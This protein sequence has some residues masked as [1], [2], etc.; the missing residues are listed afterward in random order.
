MERKTKLKK[1]RNS[2]DLL[3]SLK[4]YYFEII[5]DKN[6]RFRKMESKSRHNANFGE[7]F[8]PYVAF[9]PYNY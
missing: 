3:L 2:Y 7:V 1:I 5:F 9:R 4:S 6:R 8:C